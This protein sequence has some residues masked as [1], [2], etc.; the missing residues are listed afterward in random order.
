MQAN[1]TDMASPHAVWQ[2]ETT[3]P[4]SAAALFEEAFAAADAVSS[5]PAGNAH[6][7]LRAVYG[8]KPDRS[9]LEASLALAAAAAGVPA[10]ALTVAP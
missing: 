4:K 10:P 6:L 1:M 7:C 8:T 9:V 3:V 5:A 2:A